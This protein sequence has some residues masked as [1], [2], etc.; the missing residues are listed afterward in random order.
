VVEVVSPD[1]PDRDLVD[2]RIDYEQAGIPEYW[3]VDPRDSTITV[4]GLEANSRK[5]SISAKY[6][7]GEMASSWL[8]IGFTI[9]VT[10]LFSQA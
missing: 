3:I 5:F 2:K 6:R 10:R 7:P 4:L 8:L 9:D 1:D